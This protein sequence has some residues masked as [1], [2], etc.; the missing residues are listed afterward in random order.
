MRSLITAVVIVLLPQIAWGGEVDLFQHRPGIWSIAGTAGKEMQVIIHNLDEARETGIF[1]I[2]IIARGVHEPA[3]KI[4]RVVKHMAITQ[5]ALA[6]SVVKPL[7]KGAVYPEIFD[8]AYKEWQ[9]QNSG[10][11][12]F[13]CTT[14]LAEC[15][16]Q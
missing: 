2:E 16:A 11:G 3:W 14:T 6:V 10:K 9:K 8:D 1:H 13:L 12:G 15:M 4:E 5:A 7:Q